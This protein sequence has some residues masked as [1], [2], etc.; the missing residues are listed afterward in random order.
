MRRKLATTLLLLSAA[1]LVWAMVAGGSFA[2]LG[3]GILLLL[4]ACAFPR[5]P[6]VSS[7]EGLEIEQ[8]HLRWQG[9]TLRWSELTRIQIITNNQGPFADDLF[10]TFEDSSGA[11]CII[12]GQAIGG[13]FFDRLEQLPDVDYGQIIL[14]QGSCE[15]ATFLVWTADTTLD[16]A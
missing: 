8:A 2:L 5:P 14:A 16:R 6:R 7:Y 3:S 12:P 9:Q 1:G 13:T 11:S 10:W 4:A 15:N